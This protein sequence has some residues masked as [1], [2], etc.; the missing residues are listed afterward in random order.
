MKTIAKK[1]NL[2]QK[3]VCPNPEGRPKGSMN[4]L[5]RKSL[6][7][8]QRA[9]QDIDLAYEVFWE[10]FQAKESWAHQIYFKELVPFNKEWMAQINTQGIPNKVTTVEDLNACIAAIT[11]KLLSVD[12]MSTEEAHNLVKTL[13]SIK[14]TE[15]FGKQKDNVLDKLNDDQVKQLMSWINES[16][17]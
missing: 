12:Q 7:L 3:G 17:K 8:R 4:E 16:D 6:E 9:F 15:N 13:N 2:F 1:T 14:F 10:A 5:K 11:E